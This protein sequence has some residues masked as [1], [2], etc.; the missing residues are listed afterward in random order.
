MDAIPLDD[1]TRR[2]IKQVSAVPDRPQ[3]RLVD[4]QPLEVRVDV[5]VSPV[6]R[7]FADLL[8]QPSTRNYDC[9][10]RPAVAGVTLAGPPALLERISPA[11]IRV[12]GDV[13]DLTPSAGSR[14]VPIQVAVDVP[15][16]QS[17]RITV[18]VIRPHQTTVRLSER[19]DT[20]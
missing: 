8:V 12:I 14:R 4:P 11:Q 2:F 9:R 13:T 17:S 15:P 16:E 18:K 1:T 3:V 7:S 20:E 6:E 19:S 10:F 5:D